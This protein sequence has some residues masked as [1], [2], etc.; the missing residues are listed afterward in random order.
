MTENLLK[1]VRRLNAE[2]EPVEA[3]LVAIPSYEAASDWNYIYSEMIAQY[4]RLLEAFTSNNVSVVIVSDNPDFISPFFKELNNGLLRYISLP[5]NDTWTRDYGPLCIDL[6]NRKMLL[7]F[8]FNGWGLKFAADKDNLVNLNL[9]KREIISNESYINYRDFVL[10]GGSI[11]TDGE[12]T[13]LT[14]TSC[15]CSPNRN[16]GKTIDELNPILTEKLGVDRILWLSHGHLEGDDT[17]SHIDTL[18]RLCPNNTIIY[19]GCE[20]MNDTHYESLLKMKEELMAL[21][22]KNGESF[23]LLELPLPN[24][25]LDPIDGHRLPATYTNYLIVNDIVF[26]P[27]YL[28]KSKDDI[29]CGVIRDA[30][31]NH[32]IVPVDCTTFI[33]QHGSLHCATMQIHNNCFN[34]KR[35]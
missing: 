8:G 33:R 19:T 2:W 13:L 32:K 14:T 29:A 6:V 24:P 26:V 35:L 30:F 28:Q 5:I 23:H 11:E 27:V 1:S 18:A 7:D 17:D 15:L 9:C 34:F 3:V 12:G 21:K 31:P 4:Y 10:E 20:D 16:G 22:N 25:I